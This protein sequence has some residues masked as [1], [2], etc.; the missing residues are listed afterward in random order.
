M[1]GQIIR[2]FLFPNKFQSDFYRETLRYLLSLLVLNLIV[3][4]IFLGFQ[5][6]LKIPTKFILF[7]LGTR[8]SFSCF[9]RGGGPAA[10][11]PLS[12]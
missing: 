11:S 4:F 12:G 7:R 5:I 10:H 2:A 8:T 9:L 3:Y 1:Q 6:S